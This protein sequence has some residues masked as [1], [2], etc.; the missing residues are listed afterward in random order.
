VVWEVISE[1]NR[2]HEFMP[3]TPVSFLVDS[4]YVAAIA[5]N[6]VRS[7]K[8]FE[9]DLAD[10]RATYDA[11]GDLAHFYSRFDMPWPMKDR[12][13]LTEMVRD[14]SRFY[15]HWRQISGNMKENR[16]SWLLKPFPGRPG[17]TLAVYTLYANP[18][19]FVPS[20]FV[21]MA[22]KGSLPG[23][24]AAVRLRVKERFSPQSHHR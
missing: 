18:G 21:K 22:V 17:K 15:Y 13:T 20:V 7:W 24:V 4:D 11:P 19:L 5:G 8:K 1:Y 16:G 14:E 23:V 6:E 3:R 12:Y 9:E 10:H 2:F